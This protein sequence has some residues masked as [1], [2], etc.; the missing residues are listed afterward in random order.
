VALACRWRSRPQHHKQR[1]SFDRSDEQLVCKLLEEGVDAS[2][3]GLADLDE[4]AVRITH[5]A[6]QFAAVI[7]E[8]LGKDSSAFLG[9]LFRR[10]AT[11]FP[12]L[13]D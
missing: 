4:V 1:F 9:P 12:S 8:E 6:A 13:A 11:N 10:P 3:R 5:V 2:L 7:I